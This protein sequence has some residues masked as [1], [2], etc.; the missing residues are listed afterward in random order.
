ME[1]ID[2]KALRELSLQKFGKERQFDQ[3]IE[4]CGELIV[5]IQHFRRGRVTAMDIGEEL[6]DVREQ[7]DMIVDMLP[8]VRSNFSELLFRKRAKH[9]MRIEQDI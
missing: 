5:A 8:E 4:E 9:L 6:A 1:T 7:I 3:M 2:P